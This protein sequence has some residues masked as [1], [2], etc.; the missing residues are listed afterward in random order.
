MRY[1]PTAADSFSRRDILNYRVTYENRWHRI[2]R[3]LGIE[4]ETYITLLEAF[5][6]ELC[7]YD[8]SLLVCY[9][10]YYTETYP[11]N[12]PIIVKAIADSIVEY[13]E[14]D[15]G[16]TDYA[17]EAC[18]FVEMYHDGYVELPLGEVDE[19][20]DTIPILDTDRAVDIKKAM[21]TVLNGKLSTVI[22]DDIMRNTFILAL[23]SELTDRASI[24]PDVE[25]LD[26]FRQSDNY[27]IVSEQ[28]KGYLK[29]LED[30]YQSD[31]DLDIVRILLYIF[32]YS[33]EEGVSNENNQCEYDTKTIAV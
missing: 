11:M 29:G 10:G 18:R 8:L 6:K 14:S 32:V 4:R 12:S 7:Q 33:N 15:D 5:T 20:F 27:Y 30:V 31:F 22:K 25:Y 26:Y 3:I 21:D 9:N 17:E 19:F 28:Y 24:L 2:E 16:S 13:G 1:N 23:A